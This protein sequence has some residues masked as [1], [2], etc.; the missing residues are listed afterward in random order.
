MPTLNDIKK[1]FFKTSVSSSTDIN[2]ILNLFNISLQDVILSASEEDKKDVDKWLNLYMIEGS[3]KVSNDAFNHLFSICKYNKINALHIDYLFI[4]NEE[5]LANVFNLVK[6]KNNLHIPFIKKIVSSEVFNERYQSFALEILELIAETENNVFS[7]ISTMKSIPEILIKRVQELQKEDSK[8]IN[9]RQSFILFQHHQNK[10]FYD[11]L[12]TACSQRGTSVLELLEK[13]IMSNNM[14]YKLSH[15]C[16]CTL[17]ES[18]GA[19]EF[20]KI[21]AVLERKRDHSVLGID[22]GVLSFY[23][24]SKINNNLKINEKSQEKIMKL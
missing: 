22:Q 23:E 8:V 21:I 12:K 3:H 4:L 13:E 1:V 18:E 17:I 9:M 15:M 6:E 5:N 10:D 19:K 24:K 16:W 20:E 7:A 14:R 11:I 2:N